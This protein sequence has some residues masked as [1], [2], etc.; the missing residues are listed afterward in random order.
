MPIEN[1]DSAGPRYT[2]PGASGSERSSASRGS[3][4]APQVDS[5]LELPHPQID[6]GRIRHQDPFEPRGRNI[7]EI[8]RP[9]LLFGGENGLRVRRDDVRSNAPGAG[10][11]AARES[12]SQLTRAWHSV[13]RPASGSMYP[14]PGCDVRIALR[15]VAPNRAGRGARFH[16]SVS[17][18]ILLFLPGR[19]YSPCLS[20]TNSRPNPLVSLLP[21]SRA[22]RHARCFDTRTEYGSPKSGSNHSV[23][24]VK[25]C[26]CLWRPIC[27]VLASDASS[28]PPRRARW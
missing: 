4:R 6:A 15:S 13:A 1:P 12:A 10:R 7:E 24:L 16:T 9:L 26:R 20:A 23:S 28:H 22:D 3:C 5:F 21:P 8:P 18:V 14:P 11:L 25:N 19:F 17:E 27:Y 2:P